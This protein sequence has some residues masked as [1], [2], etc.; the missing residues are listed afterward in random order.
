MVVRYVSCIILNLIWKHECFGNNSMIDNM[1][2]NV[3]RDDLLVRIK[4]NRNPTIS[5]GYYTKI[6]NHPVCIIMKKNHHTTHLYRTASVIITVRTERPLDLD[7][8]A[9]L[10]RVIGFFSLRYFFIHCYYSY[11]YL[12]VYLH[13]FTSFRRR[14]WS[15]PMTEQ[16]RSN[17]LLRNFKLHR[18]IFFAGF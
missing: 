10:L 3:C 9:L 4:Y 5:N 6:S 11:I 13:D 7:V 17:S 15:N 18:R 8:R 14:G 1:C 16:K 12:F 2:N